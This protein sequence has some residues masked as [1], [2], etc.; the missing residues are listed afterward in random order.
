MHKS[1][2]GTSSR[3]KQI[4]EPG[5]IYAPKKGARKTMPVEDKSPLSWIYENILYE[6]RAEKREYFKITNM[7]TANSLSE[8]FLAVRNAG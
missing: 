6:P 5:H 4:L 3:A 8:L 1:K 2:W 7:V